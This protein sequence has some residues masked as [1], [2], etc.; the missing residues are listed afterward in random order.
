MTLTDTLRG[1][2]RCRKPAAGMS[3]LAAAASYRGP[4]TSRT[5]AGR[6]ARRSSP[7]SDLDGRPG[8]VFATRASSLHR[9]VLRVQ[10]AVWYAPRTNVSSMPVASSAVTPETAS[11]P[12]SS[13]K[14][15]ARSPPRRDRASSR[16]ERCATRSPRSQRA[17]RSPHPSCHFGSGSTGV[18]RCTSGASS[19]P[20]AAKS[21]PS[22]TK[23]TRGRASKPARPAAAHLPPSRSSND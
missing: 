15:S 4:G 21:P 12:S 23:S 13:P 3:Q 9:V 17:R 19:P 5:D 8:G 16:R 18:R 11:S 14:P 22:A 7:R 10:F 20:V 1:S 6:R 2:A